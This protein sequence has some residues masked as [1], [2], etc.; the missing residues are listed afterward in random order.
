M[1]FYKKKPL[2]KAFCGPKEDFFVL[3]YIKKPLRPAIGSSGLL[4]PVYY[5]LHGIKAY[6]T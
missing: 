4:C 5:E 1:R 6:K 3:L 2:F